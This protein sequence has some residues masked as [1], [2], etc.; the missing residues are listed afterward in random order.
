MLA[1]AVALLE[2]VALTGGTGVWVAVGTLVT[3]WIA[4]GVFV[5]AG[6]DGNVE[7]SSWRGDVLGVA[8]AVD[9]AGPGRFGAQEAKIRQNIVR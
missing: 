8:V 9:S 6:C 3:R 4:N 2:E 5:G 7:V 1:C